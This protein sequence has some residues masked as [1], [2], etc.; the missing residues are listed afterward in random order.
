MVGLLGSQPGACELPNPTFVTTFVAV[1]GCEK[2]M[3]NW[4]AGPLKQSGPEAAAVAVVTG[5]NVAV[6]PGPKVSVRLPGLGDVDCTGCGATG[7]SFVGVGDGL[8]LAD[9]EGDAVA[10]GVGVAPAFA[11]L[12]ALALGVGFA[13]DPGTE[14][15]E[16]ALA[17]A[18]ALAGAE[19]ATPGDD[20]GALGSV[21]DA[22][23]LAARAGPDDAALL[24]CDELEHA[25]RASAAATVTPTHP[26]TRKRTVMSFPP[27]GMGQQ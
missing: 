5:P 9:F 15:A 16:V 8:G 4:T 14:A 7:V 1:T 25:E 22:A 20:I 11:V 19:V 2:A 3:V 23:A 18:G 24:L 12:F 10:A 21:L 17:E 27:A 6:N 13:V 26:V